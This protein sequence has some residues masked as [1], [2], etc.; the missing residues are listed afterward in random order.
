MKNIPLLCAALL[1]SQFSLNAAEPA[2]QIDAEQIAKEPGAVAFT[3]PKEWRLVDKSKLPASIL[4]MVVG[5]GAHDFPP[6]IN[7]GIHHDSGSLRQFLK[8][9][10]QT[11]DADG[12]DWKDLGTIHTDAGEASLSQL[13]TRTEW[14]LVR[15]MQV[16]L[17]KDNKAYILTAAALKDE[18]SKFYKDFF[19][20]MRSLRI[21]KTL[22]EMV[23]DRSRRNRLEEA[24][25]E[26]VNAWHDERNS[27]FENDRFQNNVWNPLKQKL[28]RE[29]SDMGAEW[30]NQF[31]AHVKEQLD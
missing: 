12:V 14:G 28:E 23:P 16:I 9:V 17:V 8:Y 18:F 27:G 30:Q 29:F 13:E 20:S 5:K 22:V 1:C 7:L 21:N 11:N 31:L 3:P 15:E 2:K 24:T 6:S 10:K 4:A 25:A 26:V 19:S